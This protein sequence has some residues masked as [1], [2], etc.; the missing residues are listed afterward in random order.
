MHRT[1]TE[2]QE[3]IKPV[4]K[5]LTELRLSPTTYESIKILYKQL[6]IYIQ[7]GERIELNIPFQEYNCNIKGILTS[8]KEE[9]VWIK[10]EH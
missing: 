10:L 5:K 4:L 6:Q 2:R 9:Q 8:K 1:L 3:A 7:T